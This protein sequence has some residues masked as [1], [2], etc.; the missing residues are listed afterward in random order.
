MLYFAAA[1]IF[2]GVGVYTF[3][4][5]ILERINTKHGLHG[6]TIS[7]TAHGT[8]VHANIL[9]NVFQDHR[10]KF[11][12]ITFQKEIMLILDN[13]LHGALQ[14]ILALAD[15]IYKP[16]GSIQ[17]LLYKRYGLLQLLIFLV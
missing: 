2:A 10:A 3:L 14:R 5:E 4:E 13:R 15:V 12:F 7:H 17:F 1:G 8:Y 11:A 9:G 16:L 6:F